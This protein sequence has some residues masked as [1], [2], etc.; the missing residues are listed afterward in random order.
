MTQDESKSGVGPISHL[1]TSLAQVVVGLVTMAHTRLELL[2]TEIQAEVRFIAAWL[3]WAFF[4]LF[5]A[6]IGF[7][8]LG[9]TMILA[10]WDTHRVLVSA[11]V[12]STFFAIA[13]VTVWCLRHQLKNRAR[14]LDGTLSEL[15]RDRQHLQAEWGDGR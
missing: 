9:L 14:M 7:F 3:L 1:L 5:A 11:L 6:V 10:Y 15:E 12:T 4:A 8:L 13:G 2:T